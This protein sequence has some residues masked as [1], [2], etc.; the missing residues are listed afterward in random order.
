[1]LYNLYIVVTLQNGG[2]FLIGLFTDVKY[3]LLC[4]ILTYVNK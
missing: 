1:M 4:N 3:L 2:T